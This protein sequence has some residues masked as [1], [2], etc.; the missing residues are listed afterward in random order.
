MSS[1]VATAVSSELAN[2]SVAEARSVAPPPNRASCEPSW[3]ALY[4]EIDAR[5][6]EFGAAGRG[7][8]VLTLPAPVAEA[9]SFL[10]LADLHQAFL[11]HGPDGVAFAGQGAVHR[12]RSA[13]VGR[14]VSL[15]E[16]ADE[17]LA[18]VVSESVSG[19]TAIEPRLWGGAAFDEN[20]SSSEPWASFGDA[21][22][23]LPRFLYRR[24]PEQVSSNGTPAATLS[25]AATAQE[26]VD[27]RQRASLLRQLGSLVDGL[28]GQAPAREERYVATAAGQIGTDADTWVRQVEEIRRA[29]ADG[30]VEK[31]V[32]ARRF[33]VEVPDNLQISAVLRRLGHGLR[34]S[35]R[36]A[37][38]HR[39]ESGNVTFLGATPE[40]L[41]SKRGSRLET[42][43][44]AGTME[45]GGEHA[46]ELLES[47]KDRHEQQ[48][49]TDSIV[50]RLRPLCTH[51][52]VADRPTVRELRDVLHLHTPIHGVLAGDHHV[53]DLVRALHPTPAVGGVPTPEAM[54][55]I[56]ENEPR[57]RGWY[58]APIGWLDARG[59]GE[60]YVALRSCVVAGSEAFL[61]AGAGIVADSDPIAELRETELK[62]HALLQALRP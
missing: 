54:R 25:L 29:I 31:I 56:A 15:R 7:T 47:G 18:G 61:Y 50:R 19:A 40:R 6:R 39:T 30:E 36:F 52:E 27:A 2:E 44:L 11:W 38:R 46:T 14:F 37:F 43:A 17:V 32:A 51:L 42:E 34:S 24:S 26:G 20:A 8:L 23:F 3:Q 33:R 1:V 35:T 60:F 59:D 49:V 45:A 12:L 13:G 9:E 4:D 10:D 5:L 57:P 55:W 58:A 41:V 28:R 22:L 53:L 16:L 21:Q 48:L 62:T